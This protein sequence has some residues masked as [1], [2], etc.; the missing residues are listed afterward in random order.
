MSFMSGEFL[1]TN[2]LV[3]AHDSSAGSKRQRAAELVT[4]LGREQRAIVS[5]QVLME[6]VVTVTRKI[7]KP[8]S[9]TTAAEIVDDLATWEV[10]RPDARAVGEAVRMAGRYRI[11]LWDAMIVH[12]AI[13]M[14]AS[15][16]WT[17]DLSHN[18][19]FDGVKVKNPFS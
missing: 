16:L 7:P 3:Y 6:F 17:E 2:I 19:V 10:Y 4:S 12:A 15:V 9:L 8:I 5:V 1:D 11:S 14:E 13:A 18:Q